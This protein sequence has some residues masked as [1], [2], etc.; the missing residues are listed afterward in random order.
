[1]SRLLADSHPLPSPSPKREFRERKTL[2]TK[3]AAWSA[4]FLPVSLMVVWLVVIVGGAA[5]LPLQLAS[6]L[7]FVALF[8]TP[9]Y[10]LA[11]IITWRLKLDWLERL[12][13]AFPLGVAIMAVPGIIALLQH[14]TITQLTTA[15]MFSASLVLIIWYL[16]RLIK[17]GRPLSDPAP[18]PSPPPEK[19]RENRVA[20]RALPTLFA[21]RGHEGPFSAWALDEILLL[22]LLTIA[23]IAILPTLTLYKID[24]DA[25]AVSSFSADA[26][27]GL[28]LNASEPL[29]G[30]ALGP[31]VR[32]VFNQALPMSYLWS[33]FAHID[34]ITLTATAS[35]AML[36]LWTILASYTFGKAAGA[37]SR[38]FGLYTATIQMLIYLAAPFVRGDNVSLF[39]F[40]RINADKFMV[41]V[42]MLPVIFAFSIRYIR[43]GRLDVWLAAAIAT[44]AVSTIHPLVAAMVALALGA[45]GLLHVLLNLRSRIDWK[46]DSSPAALSSPRLMFSL[47]RRMAWKRGLAMWGLVAIVMFLPLVQLVLARSEAPLAPSYPSS[48]EGWPLGKRMVPIL[49]FVQVPTM[50]L[51]GPLPEITQLDASQANTPTNPF[52][53]WRFAV[54]MNRRRLI[55]FDLNRYISD[56]SLVLE[57]PYLLAL[58]LLPLLFLRLRSNAAAQFAVSTSL[59]ILFVMFNPI[60]TPIIGSLVMPWILWRLVWVLP[61]ALIIALVTYRFLTWS[62]KTLVHW[63]DAYHLLPEPSPLPNP[64]AGRGSE[65]REREART[66]QETLF[67]AYLSLGFILLMGLLL[68]PGITRNLENLHDRAA[69]PYF[70]PAPDRILAHLN[71]VTNKTG[72][73]TVLADQDLSVTIPAYVAN[74]NVVAHRAPTTSEIFPADQQDVA[75]ER[76]VD[77][78][79]FYSTPYLTDQGIDILRRYAVHYVV[80]S[81]GSDIDLQLRLTPQWFQWLMDDQSYTLYAVSQLPTTTASIQG[82]SALLQRNWT[83]AEEFYHTA[84]EQD[85]DDWLALIGLADVA[86]AQGRFDEA[87]S[88]LQQI[89]TQ[90]ELPILHYRLGQLYAERGL[91][92]L[93]ISEFDLAQRVAPRVTRFHVA[94]GDACLSD[95]Q[96]TCTANQYE[97]AAANEASADDASRLIAQADLWRR[98]GR[99]DRALPLYEQAVA[100]RPSEYNQFV[101]ASAYR[102]AGQFDRAETLVRAMRVKNPLSPEVLSTAAAMT[103]ARGQTDAA[104]S[105]YRYAIWLQDIV[106]QESTDTRLGLAQLLVQANRL[107]EAQLELDRIMTLSPYNASAYQLQGDLYQEQGQFE[108]AI[109]AYQRAFQLDPT[110]I[111]VYVSL[112]DQLRLHGGR[113]SEIL[114][115]L[116]TA[117]QINPSEATLLIALGD[118]L[119]RVGELQAAIDAYQ[120]ALDNLDP[121]AL[122]PQL[123]LRS[124]GQI[125]AFAYA[126]LAAVYED[127]GRLEPA[128][129]YYR[130]VPAAAPDTP[131]TYVLLGDALR[132]RNDLVTAEANYRLAIQ[133][134]PLHVDAYVRLADLLEARDNTTESKDIYEQAFQIALSQSGGQPQADNLQELGSL[135]SPL[136]PVNLAL[137]SGETMETRTAVS[138][139]Q[140]ISGQPDAPGQVQQPDEILNAVRVLA[141][142]YQMNDQPDQA[143]QLYQ[144]KLQQ[145]ALEGWA[146]TILA[147]F[148]KGLGDLY[149]GQQQLDPATQAYQQAV[150]LD[151]WWPEAR[152]GLAEA[153]SAQGDPTAAL[154]HLQTT[155]DIAPGSVEAQVALAST[156][157]QQGERDEALKIYQ[158][159]AQAHPGNAQATLALARAWQDRNRWDKAE[160][161]YRETIAMNA[162]TVDAYVGLAELSTDQ[163]RYDEAEKLLGQAIAVNR[164]DENAYIHLFELEQRRGNPERALAWYRQAAAVP[165]AG[166]TIN[167]ALYDSLL[168]YGR[169]DTALAY[170]QDALKLQPNNGELLFRL[171]RIQRSLG[172]Y[173]DAEATLSK[174]R[175]LRPTDGRLYAELAELSLAQGQPRIALGLYQQAI[176]LEPVEE[177]YYLELSRIWAAQ[178]N[179]NEALSVLRQGEAQVSRPAVLYAAMSALQ[180]RR[181]EPEQALA[182]LEQGIRNGGED[183]QLLL[184][185]GT[186]YESRAEFD[187]AEEQF[188]QALK[189]QPYAAAL[190]VAMADLYLI[191]GQT[192]EALQHYEQAIILEPANPGSYLVLASAYRL[193]GRTEDALD[194][195]SKAL[196]LAPTLVEVYTNLAALYESQERWDDA[197]VI[198]QRGIAAAPTSGELLTQ[199]G[200]FL[201]EHGDK[202]QGLALL[203]QATQIAP[204]A[205]TL[206]IRATLYADLGRP[207]DAV[208]DLQT[209]LEQEPGSIDALLTL[210]DLYRKQDD[211]DKARQ[212]YEAVVSLSPG[213]AVGYLRLSGLANRQGDQQEAQRYIEAAQQAEPGSR[214][215][216]D[217]V[218]GS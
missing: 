146:P 183:L 115:L 182:S 112:S 64:I 123:R 54:N 184:A 135:S 157:D 6:W 217:A 148:Y 46:G 178:G 4:Y 161:T 195:Y 117:S 142:L 198:Y 210:G 214:I 125:R 69:S 94:L 197:Q 207:E 92:K 65:S 52:L 45:F 24:G 105:L 218:Q 122:T 26:L 145:G 118:Q 153:L 67:G 134:D 29:F 204:T 71:E 66:G 169:Y 211:F 27:A 114:E 162:G 144:Q 193:A 50:D 187:K 7:T 175:R 78:A 194:A 76:L 90:I 108:Q 101:L 68:S 62:A 55:M 168:R 2:V 37:G 143:I 139:S 186:Y 1:M 202:E 40:E 22:L 60:L 185:L 199:Y 3:I 51:F 127:M 201:L 74:A 208:R 49:P 167:I 159:V 170:V 18:L 209:A 31:G 42:T 33:Y 11:D 136:R 36:A 70:F 196:T 150:N 116:Q 19:G 132:R 103:A 216:P 154:H 160:Q 152:L 10:L 126:R 12:A 151:N 85:P 91:T 141:R 138:T 158:A 100:L 47:R 106:A 129:N 86:H 48:F 189:R 107:D 137:E 39:F 38:R 109:T 156:L 171:A 63:L 180:I 75:L 203:N 98:R 81:S 88:R 124:T 8:I 5:F 82:N 102:E 113:P 131:W 177:S 28:P 173:T 15:W 110:R 87:L 13:L 58:L 215:V 34:P 165:Q 21:K 41:P 149:M 147:Q 9:G 84:L 95:A 205:S 23:F 30:T 83:A 164:Q 188:N 53:I 97:A 25:Y 56:P 20:W 213:V 96:E 73:V 176:D 179:F 77:Q 44:F 111:A 212:E 43:Q 79:T 166:Q 174:A 93:S 155:V 99:T 121:Y 133:R 61:Y 206:T 35:R 72:P 172:R 191:R 190:H 128:M 192:S 17:G 119:Q 59:A 57:P 200:G 120:S 32:M 89:A 181:G 104:E 16:H 163:T 140:L 130:A 14:L 80:T